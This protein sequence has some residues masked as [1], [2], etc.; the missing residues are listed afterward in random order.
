MYIFLNIVRYKLLNSL[1]IKTMS[2]CI[3]V[4]KEYS[5]MH[6]LSKIAVILYKTNALQYQFP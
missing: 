1:F 3:H 5:R 4:H 6:L 2:R